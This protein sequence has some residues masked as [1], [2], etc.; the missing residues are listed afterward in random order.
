MDIVMDKEKLAKLFFMGSALFLLFSFILV[1][2]TDC[3]ACKIEWNG[4]QIDGYEAF[5]VYEEACIGYRK[6][7]EAQEPIYIDIDDLNLTNF[8]NEG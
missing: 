3:Q 5:E 1:P 2:K 4:K 6:P 7:W 8:T